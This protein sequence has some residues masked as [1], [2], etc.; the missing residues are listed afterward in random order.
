[1][2]ARGAAWAAPV[3]TAKLTRIAA[4]TRRARLYWGWGGRGGVCMGLVMGSK[5]P[6]PKSVLP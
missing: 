4:S 2:L 6:A 3:V 5:I 1:M